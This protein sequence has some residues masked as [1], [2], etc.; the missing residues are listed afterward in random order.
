M[1]KTMQA[2]VIQK[3]R[4]RNLTLTTVPVP[5]I[6]ET[7]VLVKIVAA[8]LNPID[9]KT[10]DGKL[11]FLLDYR[12]PLI[13]GSDFAG[14]VEQTG[15]RVTNVH[16]GDAVYGR[17]QKNR[18]GTFAEYIAVDQND[19]APKPANLTFEQAAAVPLVGLTSYQAL[20]D[21]MQIKAGDNVF[22][23]AG[24][25]GIGT[26]AIQIA[27]Q[28]G[29]FVATTTSAKNA[30]LV[31][32]LGADQ[33][34]DYHTTDFDR[35]LRN[36]DAAFDTMGGDLLQKTFKIVKPGGKIVSLSGLPDGHFAKS[37]GLP[38][39]KQAMLWLANGSIRKLE[40]ETKV[41]YRFLFMKPSGAQLRIIN[42]LIEAKKVTPVIDR[43]VPFSQIQ[44]AVDYLETGRAQGKV[45]VRI[46]DH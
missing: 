35:V 2:A 19:I 42:Q 20:S 12:M 27:K 7:D 10:R 4:Q 33:V 43:V 13:L 25:G 5:K 40:R 18:I 46:A 39:W 26:M 14:I 38:W 28:M 21:L 36:Y 23:Q 41:A 44:S 29:A 37:Y 45:I 22:I 17:V 30:E 1:E 34:I 24:S 31:T 15:S 32:Q 16:V 6:Q 9:L 8:S 3:Y 11:R